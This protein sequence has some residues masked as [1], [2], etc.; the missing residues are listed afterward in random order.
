MN[1]LKPLLFISMFFYSTGIGALTVTQYPLEKLINTNKLALIREYALRHYGID[2]HE[3][4]DPQMIVIHFTETSSL[5]DAVNYF[6]PDTLTN[7]RA[8]INRFGDLNV[9]IHYFVDKNG[10]TL[11]FYPEN[12]MARHIIGYNYTSIGI[13]NI[14]E[15]RKKLTAAQLEADAEL[16]SQIVS[17][18]PSIKYLI[19]HDEYALT[20]LPHFSLYRAVDT[21]YHMLPKPD[22]GKNFMKALRALL[23]EKYQLELPD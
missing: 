12:I 21:N 19:G 23:K 15:G 5:N 3:L 2:S 4:K 11:S 18:H 7:D 17:R 14:A 20:N 8:Y 6:Q 9:G 22:P 1:W 16:V 13:E 10:D